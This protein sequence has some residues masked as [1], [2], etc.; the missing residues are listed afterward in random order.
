MLFKYI[1]HSYIARGN[2]IRNEDLYNHYGNVPVYSAQTTGPIGYYNKTNYNTTQNTFIFSLNGAN[3]GYISITKENIPIWFSSDTGV[4]ELKEEYL[5]KYPKEI[6]SVWLQ[7]FFVKNRHNNGTQPKF[8]ILKV[9]DKEIDISYLNYLSQLDLQELDYEQKLESI[10]TDIDEIN[11]T[12]GTNTIRL[13]DFI[14]SYKERGK[15]L[16]KGRDL[17]INHGNI[18]VISAT[19]TGATGYYNSFNEHIADNQFLYS[20]DGYNAGYVS[21]L[22]E[23]SFFMTDHAG[24]IEVPKETLTK[25]GRIAI[26]LWLQDYF[27]KNSTSNGSQPTFMLKNVLDLSLDLDKLEILSRYNLDEYIK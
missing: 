5:K 17:Y 11:K 3:A 27:C 8:S 4:L 23:Q 2:L 25:Y 15:R 20:I 7:D 16:V 1:I 19:T 24:I 10:L 9:L 14:C 18:K 6:L 21:I 22:P 26:A 13:K 12:N